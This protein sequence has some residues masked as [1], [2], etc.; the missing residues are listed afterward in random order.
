M[1][2]SKEILKD[3]SDVEVKH[4]MDIMQNELMK[5]RIKKV[6]NLKVR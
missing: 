4:I 3:L 1:I 2:I 6:M 5:R